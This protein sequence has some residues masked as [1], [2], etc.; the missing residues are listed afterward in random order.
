MNPL[1][2]L[3]F[4]L[5]PLAA[6]ADPLYPDN[7]ILPWQ[8]LDEPPAQREL[9]YQQEQL[10]ARIDALERRAIYEDTMRQIDIDQRQLDA[11]MREDGQ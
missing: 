1:I 6:H 10:D 4:L 2:F 9:E 3:A 7:P 8:R 11:G 5:L